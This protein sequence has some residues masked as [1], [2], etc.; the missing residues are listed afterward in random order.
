MC[1]RKRNNLFPWQV[2]FGLAEQPTTEQP[3]TVSESATENQRERWSVRER[4]E[5][6]RKN[7][8]KRAIDCG[9][10]YSIWMIWVVL[11]YMEVHFCVKH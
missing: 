3:G 4:R 5:K 8:I 11:L 7:N 10:V 6:D 2:K 9:G 1:E